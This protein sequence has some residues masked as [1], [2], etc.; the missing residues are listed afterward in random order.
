MPD[1]VHLLIAGTSETADCKRFIALAKQYSGFYYKKQHRRRLW[2]R[3][4]FERVLRND[5]ATLAVA[6]YIIENPVR[7]ELVSDPRDYPFLGSA[8]YS[9]EEILSAVQ[10]DVAPDFDVA[11]L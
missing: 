8:V 9:L 2:Q 10:D 3:Y 1:H 7:A 5:E 6:R 4:G 11:K